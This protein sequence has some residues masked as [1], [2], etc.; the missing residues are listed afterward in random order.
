[1]CFIFISKSLY[2]CLL[3]MDTGNTYMCCNTS[4]IRQQIWVTPAAHPLISCFQGHLW[5]CHERQGH[6]FPLWCLIGSFYLHAN[7][8]GGDQEYTGLIMPNTL[9]TWS[10]GALEGWNE[11][12]WEKAWWK[13]KKKEEWGVS[14]DGIG[15]K[16]WKVRWDV[17]GG[18]NDSEGEGWHGIWE[19]TSRGES[20]KREPDG[21]K[22]Q[23]WVNCA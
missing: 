23:A 16:Q 18:Q 17:R 1:M 4:T 5:W 11:R 19:E 12:E 8:V 2:P 10:Y 21:Y 20:W 7:H 22:E 9:L 6:L 3:V 14:K 13:K 15:G